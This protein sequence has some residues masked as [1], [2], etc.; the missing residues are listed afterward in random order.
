MC[1]G[2]GREWAKSR[3]ASWTMVTASAPLVTRRL[4]PTIASTAA[5]GF[6]VSCSEPMS[7][8]SWPTGRPG[9]R[10]IIGRDS[11]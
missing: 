1:T 3:K 7:R 9:D 6:F 11:A 2:R 4:R 8:K 5:D 10:M